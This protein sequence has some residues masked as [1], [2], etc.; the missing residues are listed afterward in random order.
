[1]K[2]E[3]IKTKSRPRSQGYRLEIV[4]TSSMKRG[5]SGAFHSPDNKSSSS[6]IDETVEFWEKRTGKKLSRFE[7]TEA[8]ANINNFF[9]VLAEWDDRI[10]KQEDK[11]QFQHKG[12]LR[13]NHSEE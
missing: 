9:R 10:R 7:A 8:I 12:G 2:S 11:P 5:D 1:M 6:F 3:K 13:G 4:P